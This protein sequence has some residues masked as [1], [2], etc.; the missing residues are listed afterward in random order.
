MNICITG[1]SSGIGVALAFQLANDGHFVWGVAR[2]A[3]LFED[4]KKKFPNSKLFF[5]AVDVSSRDEVLALSVKMKNSGFFP[6]SIFLCAGIL[7]DDLNGGFKRE[8]SD[9]TMGVNFFGVLNFVDAFLPEFLN[10]GAG[11]FVAL[12]STTVIRPTNGGVSYPASK[13]ALSSAFKVFDLNY[14]PKGVAFSTVYTGP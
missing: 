10:R 7:K 9:I 1:A 12:S 6:D 14:R 3:G 4:L 2:E 5:T 8:I 11:Q 13:A